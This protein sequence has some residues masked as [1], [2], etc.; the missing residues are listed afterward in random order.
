[1]SLQIIE[2]F[3]PNSSISLA[4]SGNHMHDPFKW[5]SKPNF[6]VPQNWAWIYLDHVWI[7]SKRIHF[8]STSFDPKSVSGLCSPMAWKG[9]MTH[10]PPA[11]LNCC[12][13][14][15]DAYKVYQILSNS[16]NLQTLGASS[17]GSHPKSSQ[18][19]PKSKYHILPDGNMCRCHG[20]HSK[21]LL[22]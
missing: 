10:G 18:I 11:P 17:H 8:L 16:I 6:W 12:T 22:S 3:P 7:M 21:W 2:M 14:G 19:I 13:L 4:L 9:Y 5:R 1:M 15:A 20:S